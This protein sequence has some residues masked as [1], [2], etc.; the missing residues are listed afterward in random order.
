[1][2]I[3]KKPEVRKNEILDAAEVLFAAKGYNHT[4]I[5]DI[6]E[7]VAIAKGTFYYHFQ[8]KEEVMDSI[9]M[10]FIEAGVDAARMIAA[11]T[12]LTAHEKI[13]RIVMAQKPD[14]GKEKMIEQLHQVH[15]AEMHQK[16]LVETILQLTPVLTDVIEQGIEEGTFQT[17]YP[18]ETVEFLLVSSSFLFDEGIFRWRPEELMQKAVAFTTIMEMTLGA[19]QGSFGYM[20]EAMGKRERS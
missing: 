1:V 17:A 13:F 19:E 8:S 6:L 2:R 18:R 10:R 9:V 4:T 15:N 5:N 7:A 3:S 14:D 20:L 11:D 12:T 16:S